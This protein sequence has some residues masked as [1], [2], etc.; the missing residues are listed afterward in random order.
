[1]EEGGRER[2]SKILE[3][4]AAGRAGKVRMLEWEKLDYDRRVRG[5][6]GGYKG[7]EG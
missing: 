2:N 7:C 4:S 6:G 1:M 5:K 3:W